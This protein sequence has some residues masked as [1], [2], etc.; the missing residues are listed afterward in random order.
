MIQLVYIS[1]ARFDFTADDLRALLATARVNNQR[2][3]VTGM[4]LYHERSFIQALEGDEAAVMGLYE[5]IARDPRHG[6]VEILLKGRIQKRNFGAWRMG[7]FN[8]D[9]SPHPAG[10]SDV[11]GEQFSRQMFSLD[12]SLARQL[13]LGF[14]D[15][16]WR[17]YLDT[18]DETESALPAA[19]GC[20]G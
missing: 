1:A 8:A 9:L 20:A 10:F 2:L 3:D 18:D 11:F 15:G 17:Q 12:P 7:F 5:R 19:V 4:L 6:S 13:L 16:G 14:C